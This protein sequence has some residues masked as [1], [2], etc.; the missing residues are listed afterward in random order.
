LLIF[1]VFLLEK[2]TNLKKYLYSFQ[3]P[4]FFVTDKNCDKPLKD[5]TVYFRYGIQSVTSNTLENIVRGTLP[6]VEATPGGYCVRIEGSKIKEQRHKL[7]LSI[8]RLAGMVEISK[9]ALYAYE[10]NLTRP[11]ISI[12]YKLEEILGV[13]IVKAV[14]IFTESKDILT[15]GLKKLRAAYLTQF[16]LN[17]P[18]LA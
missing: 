17:Y 15:E 14:D 11:S 6:M 7:D 8:G 13:P 10:R 16:Y 5:D 9:E 1:E 2:L 4:L 18:R 3:A 12:A